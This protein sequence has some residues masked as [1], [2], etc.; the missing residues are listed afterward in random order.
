M[1][2]AV[3]FGAGKYNDGS[4]VNR[5]ILAERLADGMKRAWETTKREPI[6]T[7][8]VGWTVEPVLLPPGR[9]P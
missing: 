4:H 7:E 8:A 3:I 9:F 2:Q 1:V 6:T 5:G